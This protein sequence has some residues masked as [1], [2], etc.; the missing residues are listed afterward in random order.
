MSAPR[1]GV[2]YA[3]GTYTGDITGEYRLAQAY[4]R[5]IAGAAT[6]YEVGSKDDPEVKP[7]AGERDAK[8]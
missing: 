7:N 4:I 6:V 1:Y 5:T 2:K 3:N 8:S